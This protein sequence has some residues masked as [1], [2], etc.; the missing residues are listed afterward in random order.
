MD[1]YRKD[2][3]VAVSLLATLPDSFVT[4]DRIEK[5]LTG[6]TEDL[7]EFR[8]SCSSNMNMVAIAGAIVA[9]IGITSLTLDAVQ[10]AHWTATAFFVA[11][12]G[13]WRYVADW[14]SRP[15]DEEEI[16]RKAYLL[17]QHPAFNQPNQDTAGITL[18]APVLGNLTEAQLGREVSA[19][20]AVLLATP[21]GWLAL[22]LNM[23]VVGLGIYLGCVYTGDLIAGF[24]KSGSLGVLIFYLFTALTGTFLYSFPR[25]LKTS[26]HQNVKKTVRVGAQL[27]TINARIREYEDRRPGA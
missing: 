10:Q 22:S 4:M 26:E 11:S 19:L 12:L 21:A 23:F 16:Y 9:Q 6:R 3:L 20:S 8:Q 24:G 1:V 18:G 27:A 5:V 17:T 15:L 14:L 13:L 25:L 2:G 7:V